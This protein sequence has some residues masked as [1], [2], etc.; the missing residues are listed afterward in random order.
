MEPRFRVS[1]AQEAGIIMFPPSSSLD[2]LPPL[3]VVTKRN[4]QRCGRTVHTRVTFFS[5]SETG[6]CS[7]LEESESQY[8]ISTCRACGCLVGIIEIPT[9]ARSLSAH[10][11]QRLSPVTMR[12]LLIPG[13]G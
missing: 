4:C 13:A 2:S 10:S 9:W 1:S 11:P 7:T 5:E 6:T 8:L 3:R 12:V